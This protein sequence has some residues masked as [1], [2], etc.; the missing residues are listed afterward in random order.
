MNPI[1]LAHEGHFAIGALRVRPSERRVEWPG[2]SMMLEPKV[3]RMLVQFARDP[4]RTFSRDDLIESCWD[5]RIVGDDAINRVVAMVRKIGQATDPP[6]FAVETITKVGYRF[7]PTSAPED[8]PRS[9]ARRR[10]LTAGLAGGAALA[11][12]GWAMWGGPDARRTEARALYDRG[13]DARL[14]ASPDGVYQA[15][16]FYRQAVAADPGFAPAWGALAMMLVSRIDFELERDAPTLAR[17]G[18]VCAHRALTIDR[19]QPEALFALA[20]IPSS[21]RRWGEAEGRLTR[22]EGLEFSYPLLVHRSRAFLYC[23]VGRIEE[24]RTLFEQV[25]RAD[26]HHPGMASMLATTHWMLRDFAQAGRVMEVALERWPKHPAIWSARMRHLMF[27]GDPQGALAFASDRRRWPFG[28]EGLVEMRTI[29][30]RAI[31]ERQPR[32]VEAAKTAALHSVRK[33]VRNAVSGF[34]LFTELGDR[35]G[36]F[37]LLDAYLWR[38]GPLVAS[39]TPGLNPLTRIDASILYTPPARR[40]WTDP[41]FAD[42]IRRTGLEDYWQASGTIPILRS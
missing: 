9:P 21:F 39:G 14:I 22:L 35:D 6:S 41:R 17:E 34:W 10:W 2:G 24:A 33:D 13:R 5:G 42:A 37:A 28:L 31:L 38:K 12:G 36:A 1:V 3:M 40:L 20:T 11:A 32:L 23:E 26:P 4:G 29:A 30:A 15:E 27:G 8:R 18:R 7:A 25:R 16:N 19:R